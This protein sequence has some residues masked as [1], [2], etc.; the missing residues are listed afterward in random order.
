MAQ[1]VVEKKATQL[2]DAYVR[3]SIPEKAGYGIASM[4]GNIVTQV[5]GTFYTSYLTGSVG[6]TIAAVGTMMLV[7]RIVDAISDIVM[8]SVIDRTQSRWGK[9]RPW[10]LYAAPLVFIAMVLAFSANAGWKPG[11][12]LLYAYITY[13]FLNCISF[14]MYMVSETALLSRITLDGNQRQQMSSI[15][16]IL[17]QVGTLLV[18]TFMVALVDKLGWTVTATLYGAAAAVCILI[19]FFTT[20]EHVGED[21]NG[22]IETEKVPLS[23]SVPAAL[24]NKY[25]YFL[26]AI[27]ILI[28]MNAAG[29]GSATVYYCK[30]VLNDMGVVSFISACSVVPMLIMNIFTPAL[31]KKFGRRNLLI[32]GGVGTAIGALLCGFGAANIAFVYIGSLVKGFCNGFLFACGFAMAADV[33]DYGEYKTGV[34]SEGLINSCVSFGQKVGLGLGPAVVSWVLASRGFDDMLDT[35]SAS[36]LSGIN[37]GFSWFSMICC[38]LIAVLAFFMDLDKYKDKIHAALSNKH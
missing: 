24:K 25:F 8:G 7:C 5:L 9:A 21:V 36:A 32:F 34:R 13:I 30:Y 38:L 1:T 12:K 15:N 17:N 33:V 35:Q 3:A 26:A 22:R 31:A 4:G 28:L 14:T 2:R 16:Q 6:I 37:F 27:F 23:K 20:K 19:G 29:P 10:L 11:V 18:T